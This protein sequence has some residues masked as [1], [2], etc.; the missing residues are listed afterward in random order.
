MELPKHSPY[1]HTTDLKEGATPPWGPIYL[2]N[3][4]ELGELRKWIEKMTEMGAIQRS[5]APC[6][7]P[8]LFFPEGHNR[9]LRLCIDYSG[10]NKVT[11]PNRY[12]L[13]NMG[14]LEDRVRNAEWFTKF[15]LMN[16]FHLIRIK[17]GHEWKTT[18]KCRY[19]LF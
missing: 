6:S 19:I 7:P 2:L 10:L 13:P 11:I 15:D 12:P 18:F 1:D 4:T 9:G 17:E 5:K 16:G 3:K 14:E 8:V